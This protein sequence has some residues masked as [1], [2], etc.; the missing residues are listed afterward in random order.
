MRPGRLLKATL[1]VLAS[2][3]IAGAAFGLDGEQG[4][5][6]GAEDREEVPCTVDIQAL[7]D[8]IEREGWNFTVS[9]NPA[10]RYTI[11]ELC[12]LEIPENWRE[13]GRFVKITP[14]L[15]LPSYYNWID[16][17]GVTSVK[18]QG[19][20]GSCWAFATIAPLECG[21]LIKD[22]I[23]VDLSEQWLVSCNSEGW[24]CGGG[25]WAHDYLQWKN[26]PCG[27]NGAVLEEYFPYSATDEPCDCPYPHD[28]WIDSWAYIGSESGIPPID[29]IKQAI[30][31][32]GPVSVA[33]CVN[34]AFQAYSGGV[35]SGPTCSDINHG[36]ALVGWDDSMGSNGVWIMRNSWGPGWG[37]GGYMYIEYGVCE[38]G[39]AAAF[40]DYPGSAIIRITLPNGT[41][42][43]IPP[44]QA[45]NIDVQIEEVSDTYVA[46]SGTLHYRYDGGTW[47]TSSLV[48]VSGDLYEATL[49][50]AACDDTPEFYF[51]AEGVEMGVT[52][53]PGNA[54]AETYTAVVG[55]TTPIFDDDFETDKGWTVENDASL[56]DGAWE[57]GDPVGGGDR[58]DPADD[59]D[60]SGN[61]YLTDNVDDNSDVDG[62]ITWL[63]SPT[64]DLSGVSSARV[65]YALFYT[66][67]FGAD[68]DN[69]L[70]I[71]YVSNDNGSSWVPVETIG[72]ETPSPKVWYEYD[73]LVDDFVTPTAQV[74]I[75][76][77]ASDLNSGSV[78]EAG[79]DDFHV[80]AFECGQTVDPDLSYVTLTGES[81]AGMTTCPAGDGSAYQYAKVTVLD[82][83]GAPMQGIDAGQIGLTMTPAGGALFY[84][85]FSVTA[86]AVDTQTDANGEIRFELVGDT[87][88]SGD[89]NVEA[90]VAGTPLNDLDV[91]PAISYDVN[92]D[93]IVDLTDFVEFADDYNGTV[94]RS[95]FN[96][97]GIVDL[98]DFVAYAEH[99]QHGDQAVQSSLDPEAVLSDK[100]MALLEA[101]RGMS[102]EAAEAVDR[103]L[104]GSA[105]RGFSLKAHPNPVTKS[106]TVSFSLPGD[107]RVELSVHDVQGRTVSKLVDGVLEAGNH[108]RTWDGRDGSGRQVASGIYF[109]RLETAGRSLNERIVVVR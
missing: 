5:I 76:F 95:D 73:F 74:K 23:E 21:I 18:N 66:N 25:W 16:E 47:Q 15:N 79:I 84:G 13:T 33:V 103:L 9:E 63:I 40:V 6:P 22:G 17:G 53:N 65:D 44:N 75:R 30:M 72:P 39:Y 45:V 2:L 100:A 20:C 101:L 38:I 104:A 105:P 93:G 8:Q 69:D 92:V 94:A 61:C 88:V 90:S 82:G 50:A 29:D 57:R 85:S 89:V 46:G 48:H 96:W 12:G 43:I 64:F 10:T 24:G 97:D 68:P 49:P 71:V 3:A 60:G 28:Y 34:S 26:D 83:S 55:T 52:Y 108:T 67:D 36:V 27:D 78:V 7:R 59:Y 70:F 58:G 19:G 37:E 109:V 62:G 42:E 106:T 81:A 91:L 1:I 99:Y 107:R 31:D 14:R 98:T 80:S 11:D 77:E 32:Y 4:M 54:P 87:S 51:S 102:P 35:F 56:T 86:T 41:P